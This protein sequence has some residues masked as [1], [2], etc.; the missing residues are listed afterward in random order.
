MKKT[1]KIF[2]FVLAGAMAA[3]VTGCGSGTNETTAAAADTSK[4][5]EGV[6]RYT[7]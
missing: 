3:A 6:R 4:E 1:A 7:R 2:S 5:A